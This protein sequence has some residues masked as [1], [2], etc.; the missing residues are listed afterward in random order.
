VDACRV[1]NYCVGAQNVSTVPPNGSTN[2]GNVMGYWYQDYVNPSSFSHTASYTY[3]AVNRL[4]GAVATPCAS[5]DESYN[6]P[7]IYTKDNSNGQYG[8][9]SCVFNGQIAGCSNFSFSATTNQI[10]SAGYT[11]DQAGNLTK[12]SSNSS[13]HTYQWDAEGRVASVDSGNTWSFTYNALGQRVLWSYPGG[14]ALHMFD[15]DG[16]WLGNAGHYSVFWF[17]GRYLAAYEGS[18]TYFDHVNSIGSTSMM[19]DHA[20][21]PIEDVL[22]T[23]W[24]DVLTASGSGGWSFAKMPYDD[25]ETTTDLTPARVFG[26]NFGR[27]L[28]PD[29]L[30][31]RLEDPQTLNKYAYVRNNPASLTDPTGLDFYI[32]CSGG[33]TATCQRGHV[34]MTKNDE[35][36]NMVFEATVVKSNEQGNLVDQYGANYTGTYTGQTVNFQQEGSTQSIAG[37]WKQNSDPTKGIN[38]VGPYEGFSFT[39]SQPDQANRLHAD[40]T[41]E[42]AREAAEQTLVKAGFKHWPIGIHEGQIEYRLPAEGRNSVHFDI[43][44]KRTV[45]TTGDMHVGEYYPGGVGFFKHVVRDVLHF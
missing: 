40:W 32:T 9:M 25:P 38:G 2:N 21:N 1:Y 5:G 35:N 11:Y 17:E 43:D 42:G 16:T 22:F 20:G 12:D 3:D 10:T 23:P 29:P 19:T 44:P 18:E 26:P 36:G 37:E 8:N 7:Y 45:P 4:S 27:W 28:S 14:A 13:P 30:G 6:F 31:G 15:P 33:D 41:F 34:G 24:G 39:F